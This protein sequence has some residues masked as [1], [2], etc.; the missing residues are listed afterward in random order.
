MAHSAT[1]P[2]SGMVSALGDRQAQEGGLMAD[3]IQT[4]G[5]TSGGSGAAGWAVAVIIR[6]GVI[7]WF[8]FAGPLRRSTTYKADI[9]VTPPSGGTAGGTVAVPSNPRP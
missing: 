9:K 1:P 4:P 5:T 3:V 6:L 8:I 7:A 2:P